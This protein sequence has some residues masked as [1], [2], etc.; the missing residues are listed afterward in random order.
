VGRE[1]ERERERDYQERHLRNA[2]CGRKSP[3]DRMDNAHFAV[4]RSFTTKV[5]LIA[6]CNKAVFSRAVFHSDVL[7]SAVFKCLQ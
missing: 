2:V 7:N 1:R 4:A 6:V 3:G 5:S